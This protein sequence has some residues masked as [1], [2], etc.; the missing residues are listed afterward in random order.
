[1]NVDALAASDPL[2]R[3][4]LSTPYAWVVGYFF[5]AR[6][7]CSEL[8]AWLPPAVPTS[9]FFILRKLISLVAGNYGN[10]APAGSVGLIEG[11]VI[12]VL[13]AKGLTAVPKP[14]PAAP[15]PEAAPAA[16]VQPSP[17]SPAQ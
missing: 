3:F 1:M 4:L 16:T 9:R 2:V 6:A 5:L 11:L 14:A 17:V 13:E 10:A 12:Q 15:A 8:D 7:I